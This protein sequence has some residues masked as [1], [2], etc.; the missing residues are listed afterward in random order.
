MTNRRLGM[1]VVRECPNGQVMC[2]F[3]YRQILIKS[4]NKFLIQRWSIP[5]MEVF[6]WNQKKKSL[7]IDHLTIWNIKES[8]NDFWVTTDLGVNRLIKNRPFNL[9]GCAWHEK[10]WGLHPKPYPRKPYS[11]LD[12]NVQQ[13]CMQRLP[14]RRCPEQRPNDAWFDGATYGKR[15]SPG[16]LVLLGNSTSNI[17]NQP[18]LAI[19]LFEIKL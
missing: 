2:G 7:I 13:I 10:R 19:V 6:H 9:E 3:V 15:T 12:C 17:S 4:P 5:D 11:H 18:T 14:S 1:N 16:L 8:I